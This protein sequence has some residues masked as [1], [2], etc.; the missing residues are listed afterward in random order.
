VTTFCRIPFKAI[1]N[2]PR[3]E[4][5]GWLG[6]ALKVK[7]NAPPIEGRANDA[8]VGFLAEELGLPRRAV[9]LERGDTSRHKLVRVEG[10]TPEDVYRKLG[11]T[12]PI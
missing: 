7:L 9:T 2:A 5:A 6:D 8:L 1:P 3:N 11:V 12:P 10:M 4:I